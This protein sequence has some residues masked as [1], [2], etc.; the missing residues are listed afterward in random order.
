MPLHLICLQASGI[1]EQKREQYIAGGHLVI[2]SF[3]KD[4]RTA[5]PFADGSYVQTTS[6]PPFTHNA[7]VSSR[8]CARSSLSSCWVPS[9][10][11]RS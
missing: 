8:P 1:L 9:P 7:V 5:L 4:V 2:G 10:M 6:R 11:R 3:M